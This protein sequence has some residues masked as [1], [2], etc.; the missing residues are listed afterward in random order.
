[1]N[2][3]S[4][5]RHF[6]NVPT[7][8]VMRAKVHETLRKMPP[9]NVFYLVEGAVPFNLY[10]QIMVLQVPFFNHCDFKLRR[11]SDKGSIAKTLEGIDPKEGRQINEHD[12]PNSACGRLALRARHL[13]VFVMRNCVIA[14]LNMTFVPIG[15][16]YHGSKTASRGLALTHRLARDLFRDAFVQGLDRARMRS[17]VLTILKSDKFYEF[18]QHGKACV[19]DMAILYFATF[20]YSLFLFPTGILGFC[21]QAGIKAIVTGQS[22]MSPF[23][24]VSL[25]TSSGL[26]AGF[27]GYVI[28][29]SHVETHNL[30]FDSQVDLFVE[31][32]EAFRRSI[33]LKNKFGVVNEFGGFI[34]NDPIV[35]GLTEVFL[36]RSPPYY[37]FR[38]IVGRMAEKPAELQCKLQAHLTGSSSRNLKDIRKILQLW[39]RI[40]KQVFELRGFN[41]ANL[42]LRYRRL[43]EDIEGLS[44][45]LR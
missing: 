31:N 43:S 30:M 32:K 41:N 26:L 27:I 37:Y 38:K 20:S 6:P 12:M 13:T 40:E 44:K 3:S 36:K 10:A 23:A 29:W 34:S 7:F 33:E 15:I 28:A 22:I 24:L 21:V 16:L 19:H 14:A 1:M 45:A 8:G 35:D 39:T 4:L 18:E 11:L 25:G 2:I 42:E 17:I 9:F 5:A